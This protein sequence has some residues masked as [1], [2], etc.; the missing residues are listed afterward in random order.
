MCTN[1]RRKAHIQPPWGDKSL[2][3]VG[4]L[5]IQALKLNIVGE[6]ERLVEVKKGKGGGSNIKLGQR[7]AKQSGCRFKKSEK[8]SIAQRD[9]EGQTYG[10][11][12]S[13]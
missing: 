6:E 11:K 9:L 13:R 2:A 4:A 8:W 10:G 5:T 12:C 3:C 7:A 1:E